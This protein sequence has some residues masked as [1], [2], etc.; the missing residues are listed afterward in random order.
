MRRAKGRGRSGGAFENAATAT[1][2][3][4][5]A[6]GR[7]N[8]MMTRVRPAHRGEVA[9]EGGANWHAMSM[10]VASGPPGAARPARNTKLGM[11]ARLASLRLACT[12]RQQQAPSTHA[13]FFAAKYRRIIGRRV[14]LPTVEPQG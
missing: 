1:C 10:L 4:V 3:H 8:H 9:C 14:S 7:K 2:S 11:L 6:A 5:A 12:C 13:H